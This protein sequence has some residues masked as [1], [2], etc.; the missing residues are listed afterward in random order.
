MLTF[1]ASAVS[2]SD[3]GLTVKARDFEFRVDEPAS[4]GGGDLGPNPVEYELASLLG[5][6]NVVIHLVA[7]ERGVTLS[8]FSAT[9]KGSLEPARFLGTSMTARAGYQWIDVSIQVTGDADQHELDEIARIAEARCPVSDN[10][11]HP[12]PVAIAIHQQVPVEV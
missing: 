8:S 11:E 1:S 12:T 10:L 2:T 7:K 9:A 6:L 3:T 5:C 4:L